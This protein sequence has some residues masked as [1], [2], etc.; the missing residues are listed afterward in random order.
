MIIQSRRYLVWHDNVHTLVIRYMDKC[1]KSAWMIHCK[2]SD[3][4]DFFFPE[5]HLSKDRCEYSLF[6]SIPKLNW[7]TVS[8]VPPTLWI[9]FE[10]W[11]AGLYAWFHCWVFNICALFVDSGMDTTIYLRSRHEL[12]IIINTCMTLESSSFSDLGII[13]AEL[14]GFWPIS[15]TS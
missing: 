11:S 4:S 15:E 9:C 12:N 2:S 14:Q 6:L 7:L 5:T 8:L 13:W 10:C 3:W 1:T